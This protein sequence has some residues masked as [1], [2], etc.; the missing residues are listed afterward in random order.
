MLRTNH[1]EYFKGCEIH[2]SLLAFKLNTWT[3][4]SVGLDRFFFRSSLLGAWRCFY[5][6][7]TPVSMFVWL[8]NK[9]IF[10]EKTE[11]GNRS[12][13]RLFYSRRIYVYLT[14]QFKLNKKHFKNS[15]GLFK[16]TFLTIL[17]Q[18]SE[19][20]VLFLSLEGDY[21]SILFFSY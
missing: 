3:L 8:T 15:S 21:S 14:K 12:K 7:F 4:K 13:K 5:P 17:L 6:S 2:F 20:F 19:T 10:Y 16:L 11:I 18:Y 1:W 9:C